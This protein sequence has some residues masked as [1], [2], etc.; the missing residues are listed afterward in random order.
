MD[1]KLGRQPSPVDHRDLR[2]ASYLQAVPDPPA[3]VDYLT[4]SAIW[5]TLGNSTVGDC[6]YAGEGHLIQTW[7]QA[8]TG[9]R[10]RITTA[11]TLKR[12]TAETGY[13]PSDPSTDQGA[14][15]RDALKNWLKSP[16]VGHSI[17]AFGAIAVPQQLSVSEMRTFKQAHWVLGGL[18]LGLDL[19][20]S[21]QQQIHDHKPWDVTSGPDSKAGSWGGHAVTAGAV[22]DQ[23][24]TVV[25]WGQKQLLTWAFVAAYVSECWGVVSQDFLKAGKSPGGFDLATLQADLQALKA[26]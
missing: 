22:S 5:A 19:P 7:T 20:I 18:Y 15:E 13:T 11:Q 21:A 16:F 10:A 14:N 3:Q 25:T 2:L 23:G 1:F 12:Y 8:A 26:A 4:G 17:T 9:K 6:V 24:V